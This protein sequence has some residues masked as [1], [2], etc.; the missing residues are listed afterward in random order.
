MH[1]SFFS[2]LIASSIIANN[3][4]CIEIGRESKDDAFGGTMFDS[5]AKNFDR[6]NDKHSSTKHLLHSQNHRLE[7]AERKN[8]D[9]KR[10]MDK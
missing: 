6:Q 1:L 8:R 4:L 10:S 3:S 2:M 9:L 5:A 7:V